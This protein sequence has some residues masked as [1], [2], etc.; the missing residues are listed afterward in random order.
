MGCNQGNTQNKPGLDQVTDVGFFSFGT[1]ASE[2]LC[3]PSVSMCIDMNIK[4]WSLVILISLLE[5]GRR[6]MAALS[7]QR[8]WTLTFW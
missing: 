7:P 4:M 1:Q 2:E 6:E 5:S 8:L 3:E